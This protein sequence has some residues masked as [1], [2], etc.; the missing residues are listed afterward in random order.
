MGKGKG[1]ELRTAFVL[2]GRFLKFGIE[3][4][5]KIKS[6]VLATAGG[7]CTVKLS[8]AARASIVAQ[9][10]ILNSGEWI[11]I[12][13]TRQFNADTQTDKLKAE[14]IGFAHARTSDTPIAPPRLAPAQSTILV[15]QKCK[16]RG[17]EQVCQAI[18]TAL[19]DRGLEDQVRVKGTGC[20]KDCK[21]GP[22][23]VMP[24]KHR[25]SRVTPK[26][27]AALVDRHFPKPEPASTPAVP[28]AVF[29]EAV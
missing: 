19:R 3:D 14:W 1:E 24:G 27:A 22:N 8:K 20:M 2:E 9:G 25:Y 7:E 10:L 23:I 15:C 4:G 21:A 5:F 18:E 17:S 29:A 16:K 12:E 28:A 26:V 11:R 6:L 13:G